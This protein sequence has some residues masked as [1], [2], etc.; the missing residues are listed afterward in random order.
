MV[1]Q[2]SPTIV[3]AQQRYSRAARAMHW[4]SA[5]IILLLVIP[6]GLWLAYFR[7]ESEPLKMRLY[8]L[9]ESF[10]MLV[11]LLALLRLA[12]RLIRPAPPWPAD[13]PASVIRL[14]RISHAALYALLILMP[15]S[16]F[17]A[18]NAWGFP[19]SMFNLLPL[20]SPIGKDEVIAKILS[21]AHWVGAALL[22]LLISA[23]LTGAIL[24]RYVRRDSLA[25]RML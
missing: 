6:M 21:T 23:H 9:H 11:L 7:P 2:S 19:L 10:G 18:T 12:Y 3:Q 4:A 22:G 24:H 25:R 15:V 14:A 16:G 1:Q 17:L 20:P 13:T 5:A 8:N